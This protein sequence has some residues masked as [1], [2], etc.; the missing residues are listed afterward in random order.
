MGCINSKKQPK[1]RQLPVTPNYFEEFNC[2]PAVKLNSEEFLDVYRIGN[3]VGVGSF[4]EVRRC[5]HKISEQMRVVKIFKVSEL[6]AKQSF[7]NEVWVHKTLDHPNKV[8]AFEYFDEEQ[9]QH[10]VLEF[11]KG[12]K[13]L[14]QLK[15]LQSL[16]EKRIAQVMKQLFSVVACMHEKGIA[17]RN[18]KLESILLEERDTYFLKLCNFKNAVSFKNQKLREIVGSSYYISPEVLDSNYTEK[19]DI[20]SCAV[21][22]HILLL[23]IPPIKGKTD[24]EILT[25]IKNYKFQPCENFETLS[26]EAQSLLK[27]TLCEESKRLSASQ[28]LSHPWI[29][30]SN[31]ANRENPSKLSVLNKLKNFKRTLKLR[32]SIKEF[33]LNQLVQTEETKGLRN[34]FLS[35]DKDY[36]G[37][38]SKEDLEKYLSENINS[39]IAS[40]EASQII[41][42]VDLDRNGCIDYSEYLRATIDPSIVLS[43]HNLLIA[44]EMF[45]KDGDGC[46]TPREFMEVLSEKTSDLKLWSKLINEADLNQDGV[47]DLKEFT[48]LL[49]ARL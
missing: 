28:V 15:T 25:N 17:H 39:E 1:K 24:E 2:L 49:L 7:Q 12:G 32:D 20:W 10:I 36:D 31:A 40:K 37:K 14:S 23:G 46:I 4:S 27:N 29:Y 30:F 48:E 33:I 42:Q 38:I 44:F 11:C 47:V 16:S 26:F 19:C 6:K 3:R 35:M 18:I 45:D 43:R 13:L 9:F 34:V 41:Q 8:K 22:L 5:T 21:I